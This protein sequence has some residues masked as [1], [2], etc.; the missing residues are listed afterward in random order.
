MRVVTR[1]TG[2]LLLL[3]TLCG[4]CSGKTD[5][6]KPITSIQQL[7]DSAYTI[8]VSEA[9][10]AF[11]AVKKD[12]PKAKHAHIEGQAAYDAVK[13]GKADAC[14][15]SRKNMEIAIANGLKGV[16]LL[17]GSIG[18]GMKIAV[19]LSP[20]SKIDDL[21]GK[22][23]TFIAE[24]R[25]S[26]VLD[27][28]YSRWVVDGNHTMPAIDVPESSGLKLKVGTVGLIMPYTYYDGNTLTGYDIELARRFASWLGAE[29][30]FRV[31]DFGGLVA[32]AAT[33]EIDCIMSD[34]NITPERAEKIN[35]SDVLFTEEVALLVK[36]DSPVTAS[37]PESYTKIAELNGKRIG[38]LTG[39]IGGEIVKGVL[40]AAHVSYHDNYA[41]MTSA[42]SS[43]KIDALLED[44]FVVLELEHNNPDFRHIDGYLR[45]FE[46]A[47]IFTKSPEGDKI[48]SQ[49]NEFIR[50]IK[51]DGTLKK[52]SD[53]WIGFD[54][55]KKTLPDYENYPATNGTIKFAVDNTTPTFSY[56]KD[57]RIVGYDVD[58]LARFCK[59]YGYRPEPSPMNF[60]GELSA[61]K[62]GKCLVGISAIAITPERAESVNFSEPVYSGGAMLLVKN[63]P[64]ES[65]PA[66]PKG[67]TKI[68]DFDGKRI[69]VFTGSIH[70][71]V[72]REVLPKA[73]VSY[74]EGLANVIAA[75]TSGK[76]DAIALDDSMSAEIERA[77]P[78]LKHIDEYMQTFDN[79]FILAKTPKADRL[80]SELDEFIRT[81]KADGTLQKMR[82]V[83]NSNDENAKTLPDYEN[84]P[85]TNGTLKIA[86]D[87]DTPPFTYIKDGK[88]AGYD[89]D[90]IVR[91][92]KEK[93]YRPEIVNVNFSGL[94]P[95]VMSGK[96]DVGIGSITITPERAESVNFTESVY[97]GGTMLLVKKTPEEMNAADTPAKYRRIAD[98]NGKRIGTDPAMEEWTASIRRQCPDSPI[99]YYDSL[100][101]FV[102]ALESR[103]IDAFPCE[104][105]MI[106]ALMS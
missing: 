48:R 63:S 43:G 34:L 33:G 86:G 26:G 40:P 58:L 90:V 12:L 70:D 5:T 89:V 41:N 24:I 81:L 7:N 80:R 57:G 1:I 76:I 22:I 56:V 71:Q 45:T 31:Y 101:D 39:S 99:S 47:F 77:N 38:V 69:G 51:A 75:L 79:A 2:M 53:V 68:A 14:A 3:M 67:Y 21:Q 55:S 98:L 64:R 35:F 96:C 60:S 92:C 32:A 93:G 105:P 17:P 97:T 100:A 46:K 4:G 103:K 91:F 23:N 37:E 72:V 95:A 102:A 29:V 13:M 10:A 20:V 74:F 27:D 82:D 78:S 66:A 16:K 18:D 73:Q 28:M 9:G 25:A 54:E 30:E 104:V 88:F 42:L 8:A 15:Y 11:E 61:V 83:W 59:A 85:N 6:K 106:D 94:I 50:T 44:D 65:S 19:G 62:S 87:F 52:I 84:Y 36:D 49:F